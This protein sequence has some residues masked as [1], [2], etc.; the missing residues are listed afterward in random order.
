MPTPLSGPGLGLP[1]PQFLYPSELTNAPYDAGTN[2]VTLAAGQEL[3]V[4]AGTWLVNMGQYLTFEFL[5]P[6]SGIWSMGSDA[7][8]VGGHQYIKS[9]GFNVRIANRLGCPISAVVAA[10]GTGYVQATTTITPTPGNSTWLPIIGGQLALNGGTIN[11]TTA[12]AG[13]GVAP[14]VIFPA[15]PPAGNNPNG[16]GG[17]PAS[18]YVSIASGTVSGFTFTS[19]GAGYTSAPT[20]VLLPNPTDPNITSGIT[21][22]TLAFSLGAAGVLSGAFCTNPG[23]PLSN[24]NQITLTIAGAGS[25]ASLTANVLQ[26]VTAGSVSGQGTGYGTLA[27]LLTTVGGVP[28]TGSIAGSPFSVGLAWRPRPAQIGLSVTA[29]GTLGTQVGSIYDGGLFLTS[30]AP[31]YLLITQPITATTQAYVGATIALTMG[32]RPDVAVFQPAP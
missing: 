20:I 14:I 8:W 18:G 17:I 11:S 21:A 7:A 9:D 27:A 5:D 15:P 22:A 31:N 24:P 26:T 29:A 6:I 13:Y 16:V 2:R 4:P 12:G 30:V 10:L 19:S 1:L 25:G 3:P 28:V 23:A 32:S